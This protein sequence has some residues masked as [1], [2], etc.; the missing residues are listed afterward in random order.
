MANTID[1]DGKDPFVS[2]G[3]S[4]VEQE[5]I[6]EL[7]S[8]DEND[9]IIDGHLMIYCRTPRKTNINTQFFLATCNSLY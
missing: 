5:A 6:N 1:D 7:D 3:H 9:E 8:D 2:L 4:D